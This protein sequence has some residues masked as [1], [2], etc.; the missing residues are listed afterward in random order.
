MTD[1]ERNRR[2]QARRLY[3]WLWQIRRAAALRARVQRLA[4]RRP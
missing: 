1:A 2:R 3:A 4:G